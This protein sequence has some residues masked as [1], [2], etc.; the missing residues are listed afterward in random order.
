MKE[1]YVA[2][3]VKG[4]EHWFW[5]DKTKVTEESG[6]FIGENGWG[7]NGALSSIKV[8]DKNIEGRIF[9]DTLQYGH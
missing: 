8:Q 2:I 7:K 9:S 6:Y 4:I 5:F 3:K 1:N